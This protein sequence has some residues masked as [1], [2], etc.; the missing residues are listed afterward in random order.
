MGSKEIPQALVLRVFRI[1]VCL[2]AGLFDSGFAA[3]HQ[4]FSSA[5]A[6][7]LQVACGRMAEAAASV[8]VNV[9]RGHAVELCDQTVVI[10]EGICVPRGPF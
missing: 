1:F 7:V 9:G 6:D 10:S 5:K 4:P 2:V 8:V 3:G